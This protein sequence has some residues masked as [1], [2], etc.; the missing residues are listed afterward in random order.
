MEEDVLVL[1]RFILVL[2]CPMSCWCDGEASRG[3]A[4]YQGPQASGWPAG[5]L[6]A[7]L[8]FDAGVP[9][10]LWVGMLGVALH[11]RMSRASNFISSIA[12]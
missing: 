7:V 4:D 9:Q 6:L 12:R 8:R 10:C 11:V 2:P 3:E 5:T 1:V